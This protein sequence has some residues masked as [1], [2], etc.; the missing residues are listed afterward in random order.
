MKNKTILVAVAV[1]ACINVTFAQTELAAPAYDFQA[2][3][4]GADTI[5]LGS[6]DKESGF[7]FEL[8]LDTKG[9]AIARATFSGF[10]DRDHEDP[11]PLIILSPVQL[12]NNREVLSM[13]SGPFVFVEQGR[14]LALDQL[15]WKTFTPEKD[16]D[17]GSQTARF[18]AI[19]KDRNTG[20][21]IVKLVK[22]YTVSPGTYD[23]LC[24]L[25]VENLSAD[26]QKYSYNL[27]GPLGLKREAVRADGRQAVACF[28]NSKGEFTTKKL[29]IKK[30][31][32]PKKPEDIQLKKDSDYFLWAGS[33]N[34]YFAA[35]VIPQPDEGKEFVNWI[36]DKTAKLYNPDRD[37]KAATGDETVGVNFKIM[38]NTLAP[39]SQMEAAKK[40]NFKIYLGPKD[41]R[42]FDKNEEYKRIGLLHTIDFRACC[43]P[44][45][46]IHPLAFGI[47]A[48]MEWM[49]GLIP[50]YGVVIIILVFFI[51]IVIHP[52]TKKSQV[53]MSKMTKLGPMAEQIKKKYANNKAEMNK[54]MMALYREQGASPVMGFLPMLVQMPIWIALYSTIYTS[55]SLRG[56]AF[57]PF[58]ITD[59]SVP[60]A[61]I[62]FNAFT[63]PIFGK[64]DSFNLL[65]IMMGVAFYLQ[66]RLMPKQAAAASNPQIAQQQKMMMVM[67]PILFPLMLYKA[68]S[69]LN[70]YIMASTF[71]GVIEQFIIRKHIREKEETES[72][73]LVAVT[74]KTGGKVKKKKPKPF[75]K[76]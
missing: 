60:D 1:L 12:G 39:A 70:L 46:I 23:I 25:T 51:R 5:T 28:K 4:G 65:P 72:T 33:A 40:Y 20:K 49:Y 54:Q 13:A 55:I 71:A 22:T 35:V 10:D 48:T 32:K 75:F 34:K 2:L 29:N 59:L 31:V 19:I 47:M 64:I 38:Q 53:S 24:D 16:Y 18:E 8:I 14:Q 6:V 17:T 27:I 62:R 69:G 36:D 67:M 26:E 42:I 21:E 50:N 7:M 61:L 76:T 56:A 11:Q 45:N 52:L 68:P 58:W 57:L 15:N 41:K 63:L 74:S 43:C 30:L 3:G 44:K 9:A 66:Q 37:A 73:G